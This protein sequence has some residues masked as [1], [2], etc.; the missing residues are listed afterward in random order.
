MYVHECWCLYVLCVF[1]ACLCVFV[2]VCVSVCESMCICLR[3]RERDRN[4][5]LKKCLTLLGINDEE[6]F[7][8]K[9]IKLI[10]CG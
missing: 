1:F 5:A 10:A 8:L 6:N 2:Y 7:D 9:L 3:E 4:R